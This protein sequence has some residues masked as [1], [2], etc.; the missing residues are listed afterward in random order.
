MK[1]DPESKT[2]SEELK[3]AL[4]AASSGHS[5]HDQIPFQITRR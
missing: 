4:D 3:P 2:V 5:V 1:L